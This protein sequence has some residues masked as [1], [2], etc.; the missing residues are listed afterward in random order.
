MGRGYAWFDTGTHDS[1]LDAANFVRTLEHRQGL[2]IA[3]PEEIAFGL[4]YIDADA[5]LRM[6]DTRYAKTAYGQYLLGL[7]EAGQVG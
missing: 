5:V 7:V 1:L 6:A 2:K 3:C 4:G